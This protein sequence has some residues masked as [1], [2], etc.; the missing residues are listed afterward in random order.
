MGQYQA[1]GGM[2]R[3]GRITQNNFVAMKKKKT[4]K[5]PNRPFNGQF[6]NDNPQPGAILDPVLRYQKW[7]VDI[8]S[9]YIHW[10]CILVRPRNQIKA[11]Q[12]QVQGKSTSV[13]CAWIK[14]LGARNKGRSKGQSRFTED[15]ENGHPTWSA[16][17]SQCVWNL[18]AQV[19]I[20]LTLIGMKWLSRS[21]RQGNNSIRRSVRMSLGICP[22][23]S[24]KFW[25]LVGSFKSR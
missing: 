4:K 8:I 15:I 5:M 17:S 10:A 20:I 18:K 13:Q 9:I 2:S 19:H 12:V 24:S 14:V 25:R 23:V 1:V 6:D 7:A 21:P 16:T 22:G 3:G 11:S